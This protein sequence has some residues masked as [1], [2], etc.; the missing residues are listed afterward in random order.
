MVTSGGDI[1]TGSGAAAGS[2]AGA[3]VVLPRFCHDL[4]AEMTQNLFKEK[5]VDHLSEWGQREVRICG[6]VTH[7]CLFSNSLVTFSP[8]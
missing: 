8:G 1:A 6:F 5:S 3:V 2:G 4:V 7:G